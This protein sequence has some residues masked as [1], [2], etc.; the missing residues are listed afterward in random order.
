MRAAMLA[1]T[2]AAALATVA[3]AQT[4]AP[5]TRVIDATRSR[6]TFSVAHVF[7]E[8]VT[9][10]VPIVAG[11]VVL[12][13]DSA[14]PL[15][16]SAQLDPGRVATGEPDRD[17]SLASADFFDAKAF[18]VWTFASTKIVPVDASHVGIDGDLTIHGV[19]QTEHLDVTIR[20]DAAHPAYH[21]VAHIDRRAF[22][23]SV[24]RLDPVIGATVDVT[25]DI[26]VK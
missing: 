1:L 4:P 24:T 25:L 18:P 16:V 26:V 12:A 2:F 19:T 13:P 10:S 20:G 3:D 8:R 17:A 7:V 9:G 6:A 11:S 22:H 23:M 15:S 14:L 21:A 5:L